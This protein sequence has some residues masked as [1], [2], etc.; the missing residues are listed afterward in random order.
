MFPVGLRD[1]ITGNKRTDCLNVVHCLN[2]INFKNSF[3]L[4]FRSLFTRKPKESKAASHNATG[5]RLFSKSEA[6][7]EDQSGE[8]A[9][10]P[11]QVGL[12]SNQLV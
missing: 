3:L 10:T 4:S 9:M 7:E 6:R 1:Q 5:W 11:Q 8:A 2:Q 12:D